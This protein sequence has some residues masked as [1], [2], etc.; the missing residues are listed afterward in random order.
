M[1]AGAAEVG[2]GHAVHEEVTHLGGQGVQGSGWGYGGMKKS[3]TWGGGTGFRVQGGTMGAWVLGLWL[4]QWVQGQG[5]GF[6]VGGGGSYGLG[7]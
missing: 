1:P 4:G 6:K 3:L 5:Q 7:H 2:G